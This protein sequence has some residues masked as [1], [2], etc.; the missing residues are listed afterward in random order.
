MIYIPAINNLED[1]L[2]YEYRLHEMLTNALLDGDYIKIAHYATTMSRLADEIVKLS[3]RLSVQK[4]EMT[5]AR[6]AG[7]DARA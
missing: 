5:T 1:A 4:P 3:G 7:L 6:L 2:K